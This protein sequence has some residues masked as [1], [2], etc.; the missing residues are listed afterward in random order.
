M[1]RLRWLG[2]RD[3]RIV[4]DAITTAGQGPE[5]YQTSW[6]IS[7]SINTAVRHG[8]AWP[9]VGKMNKVARFDSGSFA[10]G[11]RRRHG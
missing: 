2:R 7:E 4:R 3:G 5:D 9:S 8:P 1:R 11:F 10:S 6:G